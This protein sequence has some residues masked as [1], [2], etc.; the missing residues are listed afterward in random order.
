MNE[1][2]RF[3]KN[4]AHFINDKKTRCFYNNY[5]YGKD[6]VNKNSTRCS[7]LIKSCG[8]SITLSQKDNEFLESGKKQHPHPPVSDCKIAIEINY[9]KIRESRASSSNDQC[10]KQYDN[11]LLKLQAEYSVKEVACYW[12]KWDTFLASI[13]S[14][15]QRNKK[16]D[17]NEEGLY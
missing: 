1:T 11:L 15:K 7:C 17:D 6:G 8:A 10:K 9:V 14:R 13:K 12:E 16:D 3:S 4:N 2:V 5:K